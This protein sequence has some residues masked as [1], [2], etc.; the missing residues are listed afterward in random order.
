MSSFLNRTF[1][2]HLAASQFGKF[3]L[4]KPLSHS[5]AAPKVGRFAKR[6]RLQFLTSE[7]S[8]APTV[9]VATYR[10]PAGQR[11]MSRVESTA[12]NAIFTKNQHFMNIINWIKRH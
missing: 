9:V 4:L 5:L 12:G 1:Q 6:L 11:W 8:L 3:Q 2:M 10:A 7:N